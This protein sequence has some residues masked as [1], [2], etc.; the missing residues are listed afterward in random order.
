MSLIVNGTPAERQTIETWLEQICSGV[1]V[2]K[3]S[4]AVDLQAVEG[5]YATGCVSIHQ[6]ID[7]ERRVVIQP[8]PSP[9]S[10]V[11]DSSAEIGSGGGGVTRYETSGSRM[12]ADGA[13]GRGPDD[14]IGVDA[15]VLVDMSNNGGKGYQH[16]Y[17]MWFVLAHELTTGHAYHAVMGTSAQ[18]R[19][20]RERQAIASEHAHA[21][22]HGLPLRLL[23]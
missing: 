10:R 18:T 9:S 15:T 22:A 11:P 6:I 3:L 12:D 19:N 23:P 1:V 13:P 5:G 7:S 17:P 14:K 4:G 16:S 20:E 21:A 2:D 8:L